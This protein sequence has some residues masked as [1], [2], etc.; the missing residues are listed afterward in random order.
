MFY[1]IQVKSTTSSINASNGIQIN[2]IPHKIVPS[3]VNFLIVWIF[4]K[5]TPRKKHSLQRTL[6]ILKYMWMLILLHGLINH[7]YLIGMWTGVDMRTNAIKTHV[8][9]PDVSD[10]FFVQI[11]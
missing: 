1:R 9:T 11:V 10:G 4:D 5:I 6:R 3:L 8:P 7:L 2:F